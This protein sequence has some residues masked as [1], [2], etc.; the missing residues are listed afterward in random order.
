MGSFV[1]IALLAG[2]HCNHTHLSYMLDSVRFSR[3]DSG[4]CGQSP[5]V[6][7]KFPKWKIQEKEGGKTIT[8]LY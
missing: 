2:L 7:K 5:F 4:V 8:I 1:L 6:K 3:L